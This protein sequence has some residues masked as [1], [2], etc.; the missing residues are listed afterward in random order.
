MFRSTFAHPPSRPHALTCPHVPATTS[1]VSWTPFVFSWD[2]FFGLFRAGC[3]A[4]DKIEFT[5]GNLSPNLQARFCKLY[6][7]DFVGW[8]WVIQVK[9]WL[10][11]NG[12]Q[13]SLY[14]YTMPRG[15]FRMG[16]SAKSPRAWRY[17]KS[18]RPCLKNP[19]GG[20]TTKLN[21]TNPWKLGT[22][23]QVN[24]NRKIGR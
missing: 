15:F 3:H 4:G 12:N 5:K 17:R 6:P 9:S 24:C 1:V 13:G 2:F 21:A 10:P 16:R 19:R 8:N 14:L 20:F 11:K 23:K 7:A 18:A 22:P